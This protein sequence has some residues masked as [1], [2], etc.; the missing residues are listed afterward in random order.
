MLEE[1]LPA[2]E[3]VRKATGYKIGK[4]TKQDIMELCPSISISSVENS[5][6][7]MVENGELIRG[8]SGRAT[9]Y[10]RLS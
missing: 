2:L 4:F 6:R 1:K 7:K 5:L 8:G 9:Y 10:I 3:M